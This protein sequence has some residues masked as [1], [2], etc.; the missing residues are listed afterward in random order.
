MT[1]VPTAGSP[2]EGAFIDKQ[3]N[4]FSPDGN[5]MTTVMDRNEN[6]SAGIFAT[7]PSSNSITIPEDGEHTD[8]NGTIM[9]VLRSTG[10][11]FEHPNP[12]KLDDGKHKEASGILWTIIAVIVALMLTLILIVVIL[13]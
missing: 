13:I 11:K 7:D 4:G 9:D 6:R 1:N 8:E 2:N 10:N 3:S 5:P 12:L